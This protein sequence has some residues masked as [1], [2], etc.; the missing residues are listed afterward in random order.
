MTIGELN[1]W[2]KRYNARKENGRIVL[3]CLCDSTLSHLVVMIQILNILGCKDIQT[4]AENIG[5]NDP[6]YH[7]L[8]DCRYIASG[9]LPEG[10]FK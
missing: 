4:K 6:N 8:Y 5:E 9:I 3:S 2:L 7:P 10:L 1:G